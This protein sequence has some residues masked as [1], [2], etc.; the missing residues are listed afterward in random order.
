VRP[1]DAR[2]DAIVATR[3]VYARRERQEMEASKMTELSASELET[4]EEFHTVTKLERAPDA[5]YGDAA[6]RFYAEHRDLY[7]AHRAVVDTPE[8]QGL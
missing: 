4:V 2:L 1:H 6:E 3:L 5:N 8:L 7:N